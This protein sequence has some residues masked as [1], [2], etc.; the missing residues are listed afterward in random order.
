LEKFR[1]RIT[2]IVRVV[3]FTDF[4]GIISKIVVNDKWKFFGVAEESQNFAV[5]IKELLLA[6]DFA[7]T[8]SFLHVFLH[9]IIA[10]ASNFDQ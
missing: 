2:T 7:T 3:D 1:E 4:N 8:K 9:F 10:W 5:V 6:W